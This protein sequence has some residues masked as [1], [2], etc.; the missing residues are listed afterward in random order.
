M[1]SAAVRETPAPSYVFGL[2]LKRAEFRETA[3]TSWR[4]PDL[5][6]VCAE[7]GQAGDRAARDGRCRKDVPAHGHR[8]GHST[9]RPQED[10]LGHAVCRDAFDAEERYLVPLVARRLVDGEVEHRSLR[11]RKRTVG[12]LDG[13]DLADLC[14]G[15]RADA[16]TPCS[17]QPIERPPTA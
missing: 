12:A 5:C 11:R 10:D 7:G 1:D 16:G 3:A 6:A 9:V 14:G 15:P 8:D 13:P 17:L 2:P 4:A